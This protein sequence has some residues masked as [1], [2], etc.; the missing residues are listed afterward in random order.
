[1][2]D[3]TKLVAIVVLALVI[4]LFGLNWDSGFHLH[5]DERMIIMTSQNLSPTN[6]NPKFFAYGS[7]PLYLLKFVSSLFSY[8]SYQ[9]MPFVGRPVSALADTIVVILI[10]KICL[11]LFKSS[12]T[13]LIS[14]FIYA[15]SVLPVQL[16]HFYAVDTLLNLFV[17]LTLSSLI[18]LKQKPSFKQ[19]ILTCLCF[20]LAVTTKISAIILVLPF[21]LVFVS[22]LRSHLKL[23]LIAPLAILFFCFIFEPYAFLDFDTFIRQIKEQQ[24]MTKDAFV[25]PYTLQY[26]GTL[27]YLHPLK[28]IFLWGFGPVFSILALTAFP[29]FLKKINFPKIILLSFVLTYFLVTGRFAVKFMRYYLLLY[30]FLAIL[31][32]LSLQ[33][34]KP[35]FYLLFLPQIFWLLA[36]LSIYTQ[37]NTRLQATTWLLD[38][39]PAGSTIAREHW[40][41]GIPLGYHDYQYLEL[42]LYEPDSDQ[43]WQAINQDLASSDYLIIASHRLYLPLSKLTDCSVLPRHRCYPQTQKY[44]QQLFSGQLNYQ[45]VKQFQ[46]QPCLFGLCLNDLSADESFTVYD[47]PPVFIFQ[48]QSQ[49]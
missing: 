41:D 31:A 39:V 46:V 26:V 12:K 11:S 5:P 45:L 44:Y 34:L 14:A 4:R 40:D 3:K 9:L 49:I 38:H 1:M 15:I 18:S 13:A 17:W 24:A 32:A 20:S 19:V 25:F 23:Y 47:H 33:K 10:Y 43:K 2:K 29:K 30:P 21:F 7:F 8:D 37:P 6:L 22:Q 42:P 48:N 16:S 28:N 36:F 35:I 27:A